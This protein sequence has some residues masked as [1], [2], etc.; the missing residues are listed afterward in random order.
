MTPSRPS[1]RGKLIQLI[2]VGKAKTG[3]SDDDYRAMLN[4]ATA[5][6]SCADMTV[7]ELESVLDALRRHGFARRRRVTP[8]EKG[9]ATYRQLEYIKGMWAVCARNKSDAAL[10][11]FVK[12]ITG[13]DALKELDIES[14]RDVIH[15]LRDMMAKAG[16][17]PD[18]SDKVGT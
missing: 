16:F 11:A 2:H 14:A 12:R 3:M 4:G 13:A 18:T 9:F 10:L 1:R 7:P 8:D 5:K 15:A 17:D 6:S